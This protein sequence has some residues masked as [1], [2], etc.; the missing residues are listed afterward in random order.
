MAC[1]LPQPVVLR[2]RV[3]EDVRCLV[4]DVRC[5]ASRPVAW[6]L[7]DNAFNF[8]NVCSSAVFLQCLR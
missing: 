1:N 6:P 5:L 8:K 4:E 7:P 2:L 3:V